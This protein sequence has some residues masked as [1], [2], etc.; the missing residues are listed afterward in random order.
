M[1]RDGLAILPSAPRQRYGFVSLHPKPAHGIA[2]FRSDGHN[3]LLGRGLLPAETI[4]FAKSFVIVHQY[5]G[6][7]RK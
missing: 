1:R 7:C 3:R 5:F 6:H 4:G 2:S